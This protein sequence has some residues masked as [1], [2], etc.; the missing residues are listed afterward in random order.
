MKI[1]LTGSS[2]MVGKNILNIAYQYRHEF[3][4][5]TSSELDLL[6][7]DKVS[8][9]I[10]KNTPDLVI[11]AAGIVGGIQAN[12]ANPVRFLVEN[13]QMGMNTLMAASNNSVAKLLNLGSSCMYPKEGR[14]PL[15]ESSI[16]DGRLEPTNEGYALAKVASARLCEYISRENPEKIYKTVIPCNLYG[17]FDKFDPVHS[18]MIPAVIRKI[19]EAKRKKSPGVE[20]WGDGLARREFMY[21]Q[22]LAEFI[23]YA[24]ER[25]DEMPQNLNVGLGRDY[26]ISEYYKV[27][28]EVI[29][30]EGDFEHD[31]TKP[32]GMKQKL[33]D[34]SELNRFGWSPKTGLR[35]GVEKTYNFYL[36][37]HCHD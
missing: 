29:G 4:T 22:D 14:N 26:T 23:F 30:F 10:S 19:D 12:I 9:F 35:A 28:S 13:M 25:M 33:I 2:G 17:C 27:I 8:D 24:I 32:M 18:H 11:H 37:E 20:I 6:D 21:A 15:S 31:L 34:N 7:Y 3:L 16:L 1:M 36:S 5:P